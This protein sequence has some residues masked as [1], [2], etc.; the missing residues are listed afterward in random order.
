MAGQARARPKRLKPRPSLAGA[1]GSLG[2]DLALKEAPREP[3]GRRLSQLG[4]DLGVRDFDHHC[5]FTRNC[6]GARN[7]SCFIAFLVS[8]RRAHAACA[9]HCIQAA[10]ALTPHLRY[11]LLHP[12]HT[13]HLR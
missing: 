12:R 5:P 3:A 4:L 9:L 8:V 7:Y 6:I 13:L 2:R 11:T 10:C 1:W